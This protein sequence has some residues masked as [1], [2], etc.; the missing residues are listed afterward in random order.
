M[1]ASGP[2]VCIY[3]QTCS[4]FYHVFYLH[5][6]YLTIQSTEIENIWYVR[7]CS[8]TRDRGEWNVVFSGSKNGPRPGLGMVT[9]WQSKYCVST[10]LNE[11]LSKIRKK[12]ITFK[13]FVLKIYSTGIFVGSHFSFIY[14]LTKEYRHLS[15]YN[16]NVNVN[17]DPFGPLLQFLRLFATSRMSMPYCVLPR[18]FNS[19]MNKL[20]FALRYNSSDDQKIFNLLLL[21]FNYILPTQ[22][23]CLCS[24]EEKCISPIMKIFE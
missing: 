23:K 12:Q 19:C 22:N 2:F 10:V 6:D 17:Q 4:Y 20:L 16:K 14:N 8:I 5:H 13:G 1:F 15:V 21:D 3:S 24:I 7:M 11:M 9:D 18:Y